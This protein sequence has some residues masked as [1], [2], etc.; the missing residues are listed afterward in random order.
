MEKLNHLLKHIWPVHHLLWPG[1]AQHSPLV[2]EVEA[3]V[4]QLNVQLLELLA[5][6]MTTKMTKRMKTTRT[7]TTQ[8]RTGV[9]QGATISS[10][11]QFRQN[12]SK[13]VSG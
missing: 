9:L 10:T 2:S 6:T 4:L 1:F 12:Q 11:I 13:Q 8:A 3:F 5:R 7:T